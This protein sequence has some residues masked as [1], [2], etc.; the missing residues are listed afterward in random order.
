M[1]IQP[2]PCPCGCGKFILHGL[3]GCQCSSVDEATAKLVAKELSD[4][5]IVTSDHEGK[6]YYTGDGWSKK[7]DRAHVYNTR[8][9]ALSQPI[10]GINGTKVEV[11]T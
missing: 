9:D 6:H 1:R 8:G 7:R 11:A 2:K 5:V 10:M 4:H 3:C